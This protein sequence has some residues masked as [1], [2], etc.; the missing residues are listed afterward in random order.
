MMPKYLHQ[1]Q[2]YGK[3]PQIEKRASLEANNLN[4]HKKTTSAMIKRINRTLMD[5]FK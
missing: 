2:Y 3:N 4:R 1:G 5:I